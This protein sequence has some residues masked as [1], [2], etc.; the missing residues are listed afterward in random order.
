[1]T[2][3][4]LGGGPDNVF[5]G[6]TSQVHRSADHTI[7]QGRRTSNEGT[8]NR[9][10]LSCQM[11]TPVDFVVVCGF[12]G[13]D[14]VNQ[15]R[16]KLG[17]RLVAFDGISIE[18]GRWTFES[19]RKAIQARGRPMTLSFRN[20]MLTVQQRA[21]LA[22]A[23]TEVN[24]P[25]SLPTSVVHEASNQI[26][27]ALRYSDTAA[28]PKLSPVTE[29]Q[30]EVTDI[31]QPKQQHTNCYPHSLQQVGSNNGSVSV[32]SSP[33]REGRRS[34]FRS[35]SEVGTSSILSSTVA[36]FVATL[37]SG[38]AKGDTR[39]ET[40]A[41]SYLRG[42]SQSSLDQKPHHHDFKASLL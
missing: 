28:E 39:N 24:D 27:R 16:P 32:T 10:K 1:M 34:D 42:E 26:S 23:V 13:F 29:G 4:G 31:W 18:I 12:K 22:K 38:L 14:D 5:G 17:A 25:P 7:M 11:A 40:F 33:P 8:W 37:M 21:V 36:P 3:N 30:R 20:E 35:F 9:G 15:Q 6:A 2:L 41:P 19:V